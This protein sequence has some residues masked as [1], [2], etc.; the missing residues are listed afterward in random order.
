MNKCHFML[1]RFYSNFLYR[2]LLSRTFKEKRK[3][4]TS[5]KGSPW[6]AWGE[7]EV[8]QVRM[9]TNSAFQ[10]MA[11]RAHG[12]SA[13]HNEVEA[14]ERWGKSEINQLE[15]IRAWPHRSCGEPSQNVH[16]SSKTRCGQ[17]SLTLAMASKG[18]FWPLW[19]RG[20]NP[21]VK[22]ASLA[23]VSLP[24]LDEQALIIK[25]IKAAPSFAAKNIW[26]F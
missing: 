19:L 14:K 9:S 22:E 25:S 8:S 17:A 5:K 4:K 23:M 20:R 13:R 16:L 15:K 24:S 11:K 7:R 3:K 12:E 2:N 21:M 18:G 1:V 6:W 26:C 10:G